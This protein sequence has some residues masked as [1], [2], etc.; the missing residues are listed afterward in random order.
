M[1][2]FRVIPHLKI[3]HYLSVIMHVF[4]PLADTSFHRKEGSLN[5]EI[6]AGSNQLKVH[7]SDQIMQSELAA[8]G[9]RAGG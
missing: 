7:I 6:R 4:L 8:G 3:A 9:G 2:C 1:C 5:A